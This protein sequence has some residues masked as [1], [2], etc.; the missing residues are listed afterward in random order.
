MYGV[1]LRYAQHYDESQDLL[2]EGFIKVFANLKSYRGEGDLEGW[3]RRIMINT[4]I[5]KYRQKLKE[6]TV[7]NDE[8]NLNYSENNLGLEYLNLSDLLELIQSLPMQYRLIFNL[9][10]MEGYSHKEISEQLN[11]TE[12]TSRSNLARARSIL[13]KALVEEQKVVQKVV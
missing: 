12:S 6:M 3:I 9:Y 10:A 5:E 2:Q 11:I 7:F 13:Q 1:C 8:T 4:A